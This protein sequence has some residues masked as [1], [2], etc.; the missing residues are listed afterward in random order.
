MKKFLIL[1]ILMLVAAFGLTGSAFAQDPGTG[2][3]ADKECPAATATLG[4][5]ITCFFTVEN[6]GDFPGTILTLEE[7]S[8]FPSGPVANIECTAAGIT[9]GVGDILPNDVPCAG[10]FQ[11]TMPTDPALCGTFVL[12]RVEVEFAYTQF[13]Q[14]LFAGAFAT[15]VVALVCPADIVVTKV[16]DELSKVGD[17]VNYTITITNNGVG[18]ATRTSVNDSLLGDVSSSFAAT[19]APGASTT[20]TLTRTVLAGDP[21]PLLNTVTAIYSSGASSDTATASDSTNL[22]QP[23]VTLV[24]TGNLSTANPG[25]T[26]NYTITAANT[27]SADSPNCVGAVVDAL[28][29]INQAVNIPAGGNVVIN[30]SRVVLAADPDPLVNTAT[31]TCSPAGFPNVLTASDTH[32][33]DIVIPPPPGGEGCTPGYWKQSQHFDSWTAPYD[34]T[35][36]FNATFGVNVT[37]SGGTTLL[38]ALQSGG[39]GINA[40]ARHA[41]AALLNA[42]SP[43]VDSDFTTAQVIALVQDAIAPG[44]ITIEAAHQLLAAA[45]EQ[46]CPLN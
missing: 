22:F 13:P 37:L 30:A 9:Y 6:T 16:A 35:D 10:T 45:N 32:S 39:G 28:L 15:H 5:T 11:S 25:Q 7:Q 29:G 41:T 33:V 3:A 24:K 14:P 20:A 34:P 26:V 23:A 4:Q 46:G 17:P 12:D 31:L 43:G 44:G 8:P 27:G 21:D 38:G 18:V 42:A 19:L 1:P 2:A 40:L 36:S